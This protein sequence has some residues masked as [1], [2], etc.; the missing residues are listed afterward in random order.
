MAGRYPPDFKTGVNAFM[1]HPGCRSI[2]PRATAA[3]RT[4]REGPRRTAQPISA[5][6]KIN[7]ARERK[8]SLTTGLILNWVGKLRRKLQLFLQFRISG[9]RTARKW[10]SSY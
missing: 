3:L 4:S 2:N 1:R 9:N 6:T 5:N 8:A 7:A 10:F